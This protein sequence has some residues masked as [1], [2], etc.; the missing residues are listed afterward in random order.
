MNQS[1][2]FP[3]NMEKGTSSYN[4]VWYAPCI[5][6]KPQHCVWC[7]SYFRNWKASKVCAVT[8][9]S[10]RENKVK[11]QSYSFQETVYIISVKQPVCPHTSFRWPLVVILSNCLVW[12]DPDRKHTPEIHYLI[13]LIYENRWIWYAEKEIKT[14]YGI[15]KPYKKYMI[16]YEK[17]YLSSFTGCYCNVHLHCLYWYCIQNKRNHLGTLV[18]IDIDQCTLIAC[19]YFFSDLLEVRKGLF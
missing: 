3:N 1:H 13:N 9:T 14:G 7:K 2:I 19:L 10:F 18:I 16:C 11:G 15:C 5:S 8:Q 12:M 17:V 4:V 6:H